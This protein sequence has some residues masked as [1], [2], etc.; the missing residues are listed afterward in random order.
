MKSN[1]VFFVSGILLLG[2]VNVLWIYLIGF[3]WDRFIIATLP[4]N[5]SG[6]I[7]FTVFWYICRENKE[8]KHE[9]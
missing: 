8:N 2:V 7:L 6:L 1:N 3:T 4:I 9:R 5:L